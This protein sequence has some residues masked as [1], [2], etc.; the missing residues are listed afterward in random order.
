[1]ERNLSVVIMCGGT[2]SRL[3][4]LSRDLLPKQF[5]HLTEKTASMFQ[6]TCLN[7]LQLNPN[8]ILVVCNDNHA[9]IIEE[10]LEK[11]NIQNY[12]IIAEP[13][14]KDTSAAI[15]SASL[16]LPDDDNV[17]VLTA[18]H[19]WDIEKLESL[20]DASLDKCENN[21]VFFGIKPTY[22]E[23]GYGYIQHDNGKLRKFV[24]KP[25][26]E[27]AN[28]YL[29]EGNYLWNS[30]VF[31]FL[32]NFIQSQFDEH[33]FDIF[34]AVRH[35]LDN[36]GDLTKSVIKLNP[37]LFKEVESKSIDYAVMEKQSF[38]D[39]AEYDGYWCD[40]GSFESLYNH[41]GK[42]DDMNVISS[43]GG[44]VMTLNTTNSII[45]NENRLVSVIGCDDLIVVDTRD[46]LLVCNKKDSQ[47]VKN[48]VKELKAKNR[49]E[50]KFHTKVFRPWG[51][52]INVEGSD[53]NGFKVKRIG[54]YP[55]KRLSLQSHNKRSEHWVIVRGKAR[56]QVGQDFLNLEPNQHVYIP[57]ETLHRMENLGDEMVEFVETQ[58]GEY[59]GEDDIVRYLDDFGRV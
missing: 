37:D 1:M 26:V 43:D 17:L 2:G 42:N 20:V 34:N 48:V 18:D 46:A 8:K 39:V 41:L 54:V 21:V 50:V 16:I 32:N 49:D 25:D 3:W 53:T 33:A 5:L 12:Q 57:K 10:Q 28:Q 59:L 4:P 36:S 6:L 44:D 40:V 51:W 47:K 24:E 55:G 22:A 58:I 29:S 56:V 30:G 19:V 31:L 14:G 15:A 9:F 7:A 13:F 11:L 38:G 45:M 52:Y 27:T 23:T 35:T